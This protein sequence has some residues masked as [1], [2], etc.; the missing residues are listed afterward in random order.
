MFKCDKCKQ[1]SKPR[2][3]QRR[4][5]LST[6]EVVYKNTVETETGP[7][8]KLS[9]GTEIVKEAKYCIRCA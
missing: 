4:V 6:R 9:T 7:K 2:E 5:V 3:E 1:F 8:E